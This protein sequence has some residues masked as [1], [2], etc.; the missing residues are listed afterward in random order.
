VAALRL[1]VDG[2]DAVLPLCRRHAHWLRSYVEE[3]VN[4]RLVDRLPET[5]QEPTTQDGATD[6]F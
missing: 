3:D 2:Y 5:T 4:V 1:V 6:Q